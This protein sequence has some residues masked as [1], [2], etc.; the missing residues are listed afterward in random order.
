ME[1]W[2]HNLSKMLMPLNQVEFGQV[3]GLEIT[4]D[5]ADLL[6]L[7][8]RYNHIHTQRCWIQ[9][10]IFPVTGINVRSSPWTILLDCFDDNFQSALL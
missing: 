6:Y 2:K 7:W 4:A 10:I 5:Y 1:I 9:G 3:S 8:L